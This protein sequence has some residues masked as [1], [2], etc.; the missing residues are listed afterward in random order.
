MK[1]LAVGVSL[2]LAVGASANLGSRATGN[3][4][5]TN[6]ST[7]TNSTTKVPAV[8]V[9]HPP[10]GN[11]AGV[12]ITGFKQDGLSHF[13]SIPFAEPRPLHLWCGN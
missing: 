5:T 8:A 13:L 6:S 10:N 4:T 7:P 3:G 9:I 1:T 2:L 12:T 11:G